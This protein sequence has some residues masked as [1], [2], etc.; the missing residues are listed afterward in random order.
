MIC[1]R[2][3][4][5]KGPCFVGYNSYHNIVEFLECDWDNFQGVSF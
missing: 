2:G 3:E 4:T 5:G 1:A